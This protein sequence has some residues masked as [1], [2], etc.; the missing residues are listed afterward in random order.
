VPTSI[1][2]LTFAMFALAFLLVAT[3]LVIRRYGEDTEADPLVALWRRW[4]AL[5]RVPAAEPVRRRPVRK[6]APRAGAVKAAGSPRE[7]VAL[8]D[9][10]PPGEARAEPKRALRQRFR[11]G[12]RKTREK[13]TRDVREV[14]ATGATDESFESLEEVLVA[15]DV[16]V[17]TATALADD[18]RV[19]RAEL[20][21]GDVHPTLKQLMIARLGEADRR[22][23]LSREKT[24]IW[25][26]CGV[27]GTGKTT[28]IAKLAARAQ[29]LGIRT[30]LAA[31]DTFRAAAAEQLEE[32][33]RRVGVPV[34]R[35]AAGADPGAVV[36][37]AIAHAT[38]QD[39]N[40]VIVDTAGRLHTR[41]PLMDELKKVLRV[42]GRAQDV[43]M[44]ECLLVIDATTGQNG[45]AQAKA[46]KDAA[47]VTGL[48][49]AKLDGTAKGGVVF[50]V[51]QELGV[52]VKAVGTGEHY[53]D[54]VPF[55]PEAFV[56]ALLGD[57]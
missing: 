6:P 51:E 17:A 24:S 16:G 4:G 34:I 45:I 29:S 2:Q 23:R 56:D 36:F 5:G 43:V 7:D 25:V 1:G 10:P 13:L 26:V 38:A 3:L 15:A 31:A 42:I 54:L 8:S 21:S 30:C 47:G 52:P 46:F 55:E 20:T 40:L 33:G 27:N 41:K 22:L 48:V 35:Q 37:D 32:W 11:A 53:R 12:L 9:E 44:T 39:L 50:A 57:A 18:L 28:S 19:R 49:L 14:F